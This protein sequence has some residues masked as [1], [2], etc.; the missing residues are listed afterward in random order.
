MA[1]AVYV[2]LDNAGM[3]LLL[4]NYTKCSQVEVSTH[5]CKDKQTHREMFVEKSF[6]QNPS[7]ILN[8]S[9]F[10]PLTEFE[11]IAGKI[12]TQNSELSFPAITAITDWLN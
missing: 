12:K 8:A 3:S 10:S 1:F 5:T 4:L 9:A 2:G 6:C 7:A 11:C